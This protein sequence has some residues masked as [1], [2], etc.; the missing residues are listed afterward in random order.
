MVRSIATI[1]IL[2]SALATLSACSEARSNDQYPSLVTIAGRSI[3][4]EAF[5]NQYIDYL[6]RT[7]LPDEARL[8]AGFLEQTITKQ[9]VVHEARE[10]GIETEAAYQFQHEKARRKLLLAAF[11]DH[12]LF[13]TL[14]ARDPELAEMLMRRHISAARCNI[15]EK[16][17]ADKEERGEKHG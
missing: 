17:N 13:D 3:S 14:Q 15:E 8:R 10:G 9:L 1:V 16:L 5:R 2:T 7:G 12:A 6:A 4:T 11:I